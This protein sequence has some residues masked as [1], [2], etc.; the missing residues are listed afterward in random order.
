MDII[1]I[2]NNII[3]KKIN[4]CGIIFKLIIKLIIFILIN[5]NIFKIKFI[6]FLIKIKY[7]ILKKINLY[8]FKI[9]NINNIFINFFI[10]KDFLLYLLKNFL[11]FL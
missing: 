8:F 9:F 3:L 11:K 6:Y 7:I 4:F 5:I 2:K 1:N 10:I